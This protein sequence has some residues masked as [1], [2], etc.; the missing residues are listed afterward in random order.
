MSN[1]K[2][3]EHAKNNLKESETKLKTCLVSS[4]EKIALLLDHEIILNRNFQAAEKRHDQLTKLGNVL[5]DDCWLTIS[6][7]G[8]TVHTKAAKDQ[9]IFCV[10]CGSS[11]VSMTQIDGPPQG[12]EALSHAEK[13]CEE[14]KE[15]IGGKSIEQ[16]DTRTHSYDRF[17]YHM[18]YSNRSMHKGRKNLSNDSSRIA[19][20]WK[21]GYSSC[22]RSPAR[23][24]KR[25]CLSLLLKEKMD[26]AKWNLKNVN[27]TIAEWEKYYNQHNAQLKKVQAEILKVKNREINQLSVRNLLIKEK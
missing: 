4:Q 23:S 21:S 19:Q 7:L 27:D 20:S 26:S 16:C 15:A 13:A 2:Q 8:E 14:A 11:M 18:S 3:L 22:Y 24:K 9:R 1:F 10:N 12:I 25:E 5:C 6:I 17:G